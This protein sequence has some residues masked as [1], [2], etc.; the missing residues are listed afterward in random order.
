M[1]VAAGGSY[2]TGEMDEFSDLDLVIAVEPDAYESAINDRQAIA[3]TLGRLLV[4]FTGE[5]VGEPRLL[6]CLYGPP[7][8]HVD[9]KFV[10]LAEIA[11]R[12]EDPA[13]LWERDGRLS[14]ALQGQPAGYPIPD[15]QWI[16]D[17]FWT[18]IHYGASK[19]GR[20]E[21]FEAIDGLGFIRA[22]VLG[23]L[24]C[25]AA[26]MRPS[27]VRKLERLLPDRTR[28]FAST[29]AV[30]DGR[31]CAAALR[32]T[33]D[34]HLNLRAALASPGLTTHDA[35]EEA[36]LAYLSEIEARVTNAG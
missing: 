20:G 10:S 31:S 23:P 17:R 11:V 12:V 3:A 2:L 29:L 33:S 8:L 26:G 13:I 14:A 16:E 5:H 18:W 28:E 15:L 30:H 32:A 21:L 6:I 35:A 1:G 36:A 4:A 22:R 25:L 24:A 7:L 27:G 9:L 34:L 19:I